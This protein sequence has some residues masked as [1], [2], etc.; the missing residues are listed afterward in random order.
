MIPTIVYLS[1]ATLDNE[2]NWTALEPGADCVVWSICR[3][4]CQHFNIDLYI[5]IDHERLQQMAEIGE[6]NTCAQRWLE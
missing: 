1:R 2:K 4:P 5:C 6:H 3:L